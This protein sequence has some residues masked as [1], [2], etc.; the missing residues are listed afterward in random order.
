MDYLFILYILVSVGVSL[1]GMVMLIQSE[2][3]LGGFLF[4]IG[5]VLVFTFYGLRWFYGENL[6]ITQY[7]SNQWPP[8]INTCPDFLTLT[9]DAS[10]KQVCIDMVGVAT[11]GIQ[12]FVD[13]A[14]L[15]KATHTF[16]LHRNKTGVARNKALCDETKNQNLTWEGIYDGQSCLVPTS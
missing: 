1:G 6:K 3:T 5:C 15:G 4:L 11:S 7:T 14:N 10:G 16:Q 13:Q 2:R 12:K 9:K 8:I